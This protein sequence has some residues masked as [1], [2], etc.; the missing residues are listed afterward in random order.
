MSPFNRAISSS[1][2]RLFNETEDGSGAENE[3]DVKDGGVNDLK[4]K[5]FGCH[6]LLSMSTGI[7][8]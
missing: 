7:E 2:G 1:R 6:I 5:E 4:E 3:A 8:T